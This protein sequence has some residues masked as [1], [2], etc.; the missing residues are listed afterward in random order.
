MSPISEHGS[1]I[2]SVPP[3]TPCVLRDDYKQ[4]DARTPPLLCW[5]CSSV[6]YHDRPMELVHFFLYSEIL[7]TAI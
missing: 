7:A 5:N 4:Q 1:A 2:G 6:I 3:H